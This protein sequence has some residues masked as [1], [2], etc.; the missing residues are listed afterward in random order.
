MRRD[1][2]PIKQLEPWESW[3]LWAMG[4][5]NGLNIV[6]WY[7]LSMA[8]VE[9]PELPIRIFAS[10]AIYLPFIALL[11]G[12]AQMISLDGALIATI[13]G[14]R[15]GR[16]S[17]WSIFTIIGAGLFSAAISYAVHSGRIDQL[18]LLHVAS[19][20]NL[21]LYNMHLAQP[22]KDLHSGSG[23]ASDLLPTR[24]EAFGQTFARTSVPEQPVYPPP[25]LT[26][27]VPLFRCKHCNQKVT[28]PV[29]GQHGKNVKKY[30]TCKSVLST[31]I[32]DISTVGT[33]ETG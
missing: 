17:W 32:Y 16:R 14:M 13:A 26:D 30:G 20:V 24:T 9:A 2:K 7:V 19:A 31:S 33:D 3:P 6:L 15:N 4:L 27:T 8:R 18:P 21:V 1:E 10:L 23:T 11:G 22:R 25:I 29:L 12:I 28:F 5:S